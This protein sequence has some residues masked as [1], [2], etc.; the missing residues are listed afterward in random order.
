MAVATVSFSAATYSIEEN[1]GPI[2][3]PVIRGGDTERLAVVLVA[4]DIFQ[5]SASGTMY[6]QMFC[7]VTIFPGTD[8]LTQNEQMPLLLNKGCSLQ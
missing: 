6:F 1:A 4:A 2:T 5:G 7:I 8:V 3:V